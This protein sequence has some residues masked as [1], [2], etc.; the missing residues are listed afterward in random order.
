M[1]FCP[2][3]KS[4]FADSEAF[5]PNCGLP[6]EVAPAQDAYAPQQPGYAP[7]QPYAAAPAYTDPTDHT[8]EFAA[9]DISKNKIVAMLPYLMGFLGIIVAALI[10]G[11][12]S[13]YVKFHVREALKINVL[14]VLTATIMMLTFWLVLPLIAGGIFVAILGVVNIICFFSVCSG[15]AKEAP[16]VKTFTFLK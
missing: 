5:C 14:S 15:K 2:Q 12:D 13:P 11:N 10:G 7:Q 4:T 9:E 6:L 1:K 3:C 16:I 8:A